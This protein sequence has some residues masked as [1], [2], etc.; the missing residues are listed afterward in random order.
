MKKL[1]KIAAAVVA[2]VLVAALVLPLALRGR[3]GEIVKSEANRVLAA[4]LDFESLDISLL[5][6]FP[7]ASLELRGLTLVG[8]ERFEGDT[9]VA[10]DRISVAVD[11]MSLF[12]DEGFEVSK[13]LLVRPSVYGHKAADGAVNWDVMKPSD[14]PQQESEEDSADDGPST[15]RLSLK[16]FDIEG[17]SLRYA[18][19]STGMYAATSP[20]DLSL[21]GDMSAD[22]TDLAL[23]L[24]CKGLA[25]RTGG[26]AMLSGAEAGLDAVISADLLNNRFT[27]SDNT[28]RLNN[29]LLSL[30]GWAELGEESVKMD[31]KANTSR[32]GFRDILSMIPAFYTRDFAELSADGSMTLAASVAG[33]MR[34]DRMPAFDVR[35]GVSDGSFRYASL[36]QGV[37]GI[38]VDAAVSNPGGTLD[39]TKVDVD[40]FTLTFAGNTLGA[41]LHAAT[42]LSD[43]RFSATADGRVDLGAVKDVY[44]L[45]DSVKL[46]GKVTVDLRA[47]ARMSDI[48]AERFE[49]V[50]AEGSFAVEDMVADVAGL[51]E[52]RIRRAA[53]SITPQAMTLSELGVTLGRSDLAARGRLTNYLAYA[54][55]GETL[56]GS[57][58]VTSSLLDL[59]E[60]MGVMP[61]G[62]DSAAQEPAEAE[63]AA[64]PVSLAVPKNLDLTLSTTLGR[65]LFQKMEISDFV[66]ALRVRN[67]ILSVDRLAMG[68]FGGSFSSQ[69]AVYDTSNP[70][71]PTLRL[72]CALKN[73]SFSQTFSQLDMVKNIV[74]LFEKTGG[75]YSMSLDMS[76]RMSPDLTPDLMSLNAKG[77]ISSQNIRL[78]N[79]EAF[80]KL[81]DALK[82][83]KLRTIEASDVKISFTVADGRVTTKPFDLRMGGVNL[84][85]SG[86]TGLDST[87]DYTGKVSL[88]AGATG[89]VLSNVALKIGGTFSSPTV[90]VDLKA[91]AAEAV[92]NVVN[93][94]L[95][96]MTGSENLSEEF[97]RQ[98]EKLRAEAA[99]AGEALV[100][101]AGKQRQALIDK[102]GSKIAKLAA[103]KSGDLLVKEAEKQSAKLQAEAE[104]QIEALR[105]KMTK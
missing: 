9:I 93:D 68:I 59:N 52:V 24:T 15:F 48:E 45:G 51:P 53:A 87:I 40:R 99:R 7:K 21:R 60:I 47:A 14:E 76:T 23:K 86:S 103:E 26:I 97:E 49:K 39:A 94:Q 8:V 73:A 11:V 12:G 28:L 19:D 105:E 27:L 90:S 55:R 6:R 31:L 44:P 83:D 81:A 18:D 64:E 16:A 22:R 38:N 36:P 42:P 88:P 29:I 61:A 13:V 84:T 46:D 35:L 2:V 85:L 89:G 80:D 5:R 4:R 54:L 50:D 98:A 74:P 10:A 34:G 32:V 102:A 70:E 65:V 37:T 20:V 101:E 33:E 25:F 57:L 75:D 69:S 30:D 95:K 3:I 71:V 82:N 96:K 91:A 62:D 63:E 43:L 17:A 92:T 66:G 77:E 56:K 67:G 79:V 41:T 1:L 78:Q 72:A 100:K 58:T 104:K